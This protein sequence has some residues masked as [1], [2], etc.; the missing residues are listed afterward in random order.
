MM[1]K[2]K[3]TKPTMS[4]FDKMWEAERDAQSLA[5]AEAIKTDGKRLKA[6]KTAAKRLVSEERKTAKEAEKRAKAMKKIAK[7]APKRKTKKK[8]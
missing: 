6:A 7:P 3:I 2:R 1:A 4:A 5:N 8:K